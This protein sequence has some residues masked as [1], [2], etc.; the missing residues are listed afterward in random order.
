METTLGNIIKNLATDMETLKTTNKEM[1][2]KNEELSEIVTSWQADNT[3]LKTESAEAQQQQEQILINTVVDLQKYLKSKDEEVK[4]LKTNLDAARKTRISRHTDAKSDHLQAAREVLRNRGKQS[5]QLQT[6]AN[7]EA[8]TVK[9][10]EAVAHY[11]VQPQRDR[12]AVSNASP[13][14][15]SV[16]PPPNEQIG[17]HT[18]VEIITHHSSNGDGVGRASLPPSEDSG[19]RAM[20][21]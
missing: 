17:T 20:Q 12:R 3:L 7:E 16:I 21:E 2:E 4:Q 9:E 14:H 6:P 11:Q 19:G 18:A 5:T 1:A 10:A 8:D 15:P 13:S